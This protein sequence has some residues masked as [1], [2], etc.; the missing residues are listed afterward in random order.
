MF[1]IPELIALLKTNP[2]FQGGLTL[3]VLGLAFTYLRSIPGKIWNFCKNRMVYTVNTTAV[4]DSS[5]E[6]VYEVIINEINKLT[7]F[8]RTRSFMLD[9]SSTWNHLI[10]D[11]EYKISYSPVN[12]YNFV[13]YK[14][15][16]FLVKTSVEDNRENKQ[17]SAFTLFKDFSIMTLNI[18][19]WKKNLREF[20]DTTWENHIDKYKDFIKVYTYSGSDWALNRKTLRRSIDTIYCDKIPELVMDLTTFLE[21]KEWYN[22]R[23]IQHQRGILLYGPPGNGKTSII[24]GLA[25]T[26]NLPIYQL[27]CSE[28]ADMTD[29]SF[30]KMLVRLGRKSILVIEDV[31]SLFDDEEDKITMDERLDEPLA[32]GKVVRKNVSAKSKLTLSGLLNGLDG[33]IQTDNSRIIIMTTNNIDAIDPAVLRSGRIDSTVFIGNATR[34]NI[35]KM[36]MN[37]FPEHDEALADNFAN[38]YVDGEVCMAKIQ[39]KLMKIK[40]DSDKNKKENA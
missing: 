18:N 14:N 20:I 2:F 17:A 10:N 28:L 34:N 15:S 6:Q 33:I 9:S 16:W 37:F 27:R 32:A 38:D 29:Y 36:Y 40:E 13:K 23:E 24:R 11:Y 3:T 7:D 39:D 30:E 1:S 25:T 5:T 26:L 22:S 12:G 19:S 4:K 31:D 35:K 8:K 21:Q